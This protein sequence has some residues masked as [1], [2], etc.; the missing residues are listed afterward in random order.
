MTTRPEHAPSSIHAGGKE[1]LAAETA[2]LARLIAAHAPF[3]G[4]FDLSIPGVQA[5]RFSAADVEYL[6]VFEWPALLIAAQGAKTV[7]VGH[8]VYA[9]GRSGMLML[10]V[11]LPIAMKATEAS[12]TE[13]FLGVKLR[14]DPQ[15]IAGLVLKLYPQGLPAAAKRGTGYLL[16]ADLGLIKA[17]SRLMEC[18]ASPSDVQWLAPLTMEEILIRVLRSPMGGRVAEI[19]LADSGVNRVSQ[20][21]GWLKDNYAQPVKI[22]ELA[23]LAHMSESA[24]R[25]H[26]KSITSMSPLQYQKAL[27]LHEARRLM[28]SGALDA[29]AAAQQV[30]YISNSQFNR[31]YSK[32]FGSP[33]KRDIAGLRQQTPPF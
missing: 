13:P 19:G 12:Y 25:E 28:I 31:E 7:T 3:D 5:S 4:T 15:Q 22:A 21:I 18:L 10:P 2:R 27:R 26:F 20:A 33:P 32:F 11:A 16:E 1:L 14:L 17:L 6:K 9:F 8:E 23:D 30:G 24:F 29:N